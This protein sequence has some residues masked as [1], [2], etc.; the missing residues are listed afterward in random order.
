VKSLNLNAE[1]RTDFILKYFFDVITR[2]FFFIL[3]FKRK[4]LVYYL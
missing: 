2:Y 3:S 4:R 1:S